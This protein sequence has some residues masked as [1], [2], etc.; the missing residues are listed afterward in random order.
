MAALLLSAAG[1]LR[2]RQVGALPGAEPVGYGEWH[3]C[4]VCN[5]WVP[6]DWEAHRSGGRHYDN[7]RIIMV[8]LASS[9]SSSTAPCTPANHIGGHTQAET[10]CGPH[11]S[12][13]APSARWDPPEGA[14]PVLLQRHGE[15][16]P[17][18]SGLFGDG[19]VA[20]VAKAQERDG[21]EAFA[22]ACDGE[23]RDLLLTRAHMCVVLQRALS[24][25]LVHYCGSQGS[26]VT[27]AY[28]SRAPV[29]QDWHTAGRHV[30]TRATQ[31]PQTQHL[32]SR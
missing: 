5:V 14:V 4:H 24:Q 8:Q 12:R 17:R 20:A 29:C 32:A 2:L 1:M 31:M 10:C 9:C 28:T 16:E 6:G 7:L 18:G 15:C 23:R 21:L 22:V 13:A 27:L 3:W 26:S 25:E 19:V 30:T 11:Q